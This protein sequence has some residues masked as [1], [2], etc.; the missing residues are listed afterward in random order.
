MRE[1]YIEGLAPHGGPE[2]CVGACEG[3]GEALT[4]VR[5]GWVMEPRNQGVRGADAVEQVG[6]QHRWWCYARVARGPRAV[7][8]PVHV[9]NLHAREPGDP[10]IARPVDGRVGRSGNAEAVSLR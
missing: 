2:S 6:R 7:G 5:A 8:E 3:V 1:L 9:R 4:G 10:T